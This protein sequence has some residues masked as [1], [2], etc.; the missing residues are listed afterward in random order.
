MSTHLPANARTAPAKARLSRK[1][2]ALAGATGAVAAG[3]AEA[4]PYTPTAGVAAAQG[5]PGFSFVTSTNVTLGTLRPPASPGSTVWDI[6][7]VGGADFQLTH[8]NPFV[9]FTAARILQNQSSNSLLGSQGEGFYLQKLQ[10]GFDVAGGVF[11]SSVGLTFNGV[12]GNATDF[13]LGDPGQFGFKFI[14]GEF[15]HYGW[16]SLVIDGS[17]VGQGFQI[18]EAYYQTTP[19]TPI[20][21]GQV[22]QAVPEPS[23]MALLAIGAAGVTAWR[24][25]RK[26]AAKSE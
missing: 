3:T 7:G 9:G 19:G 1:L 12:L 6:D 10:T 18:T 14:S 22:P 15:T 23:S 11:G 20:L 5:I 8:S 26:K 13:T 16:G 25:R 4:V 21:V 17:P 2:A 24:A